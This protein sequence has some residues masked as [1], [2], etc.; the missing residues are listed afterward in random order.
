MYKDQGQE[1]HSGQ[2]PIRKWFGMEEKR[3]VAFT[4]MLAA[5]LLTSTKLVVGLLTN[6]L[7]ILSE[8]LHS[9]LD[10]IA[11]GMTLYAVSVS[12]K[13]ADIEHQYGHERIENF[14]ALIETILLLF[15]VA[16]VIYEAVRRIIMLDLNVDTNIFAFSVVILAIIVDFSRS[17]ALSRVAK[18]YD[19]QALEADALHFRSDIL[20]SSIVFVGLLSTHFGFTF[21]D[22]L[23]A[24]GVAIV[25]LVMTLKLGKETVEYLLDR[26]PKGLNESIGKA[27]EEIEGVIACGR[28]RIRKAGPVTFVEMGIFIDESES[29]SGAQLIRQRVTKAITDVVGPAD[30]TISIQP[31]QRGFQRL[32]ESIRHE[33]EKLEWIKAISSVHAF[34]FAD[35][36]WITLTIGVK[37]NVT[38]GESYQ[39]ITQLEDSLQ[40]KFGIIT[41]IITHVEPVLDTKYPLIDI[42]RAKRRIHSLV[43]KNPLLK[44]CHDVKIFPISNKNYSLTLNCLANPLLSIKK[45]HDATRDLEIVIREE[46]PTISQIVI[47]VKPE[48]RKP[49]NKSDERS[50]RS[51]GANK[52]RAE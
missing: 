41:Q 36:A 33:C 12:S 22:P 21:G 18:K 46:F 32:I 23:G 8:A 25:V 47:E 29:I 27:V 11:A 19:S 13:P 1:L 7:G 9:A 30:V 6:S 45:V 16:W 34:E 4:S 51:K 3:R 17:R 52:G 35:Q 49:L 40:E 28:I 48:N 50:V 10:L 43:E 44:Q 15:T 39:W 37:G 2:K 5:I 42:A 24:I 14:S 26:A 31:D 38:L 20:S